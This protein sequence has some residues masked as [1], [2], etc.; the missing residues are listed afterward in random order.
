MLKAAKVW[1]LAFFLTCTSAYLLRATQIIERP[2]AAA[3]KQQA[4]A[5]SNSTKGTPQRPCWE[6]VEQL[7]IQLRS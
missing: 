5:Q 4:G 7:H 6:R 1:G 3:A 2:V